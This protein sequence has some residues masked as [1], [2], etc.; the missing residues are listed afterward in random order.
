ML[1]VLILPDLTVTVF[2]F[3]DLLAQGVKLMK[4]KILP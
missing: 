4:N 3:I 2:N 1:K